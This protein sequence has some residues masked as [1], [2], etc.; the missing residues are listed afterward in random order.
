MEKATPTPP[1]RS[2]AL[3]ALWGAPIGLLGGLIRLDLGRGPAADATHQT[4]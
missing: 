3:A 4:G 2:P 1:R